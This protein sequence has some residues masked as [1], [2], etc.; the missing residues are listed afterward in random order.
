ML[1]NFD[2][3]IRCNHILFLEVIKFGSSDVTVGVVF[4]MYEVSFEGV[5]DLRFG[6]SF[7]LVRKKQAEQAFFKV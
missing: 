4:S 2:T 7:F 1:N 6:V 5:W 3:I